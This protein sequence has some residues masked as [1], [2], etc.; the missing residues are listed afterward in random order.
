[1]PKDK[2]QVGHDNLGSRKNRR[3]RGG[4]PESQAEK[5]QKVLSEAGDVFAK[6]EQEKEEAE[7]L[8]QEERGPRLANFK[9]LVFL[10]RMNTKVTVGGFI[11]SMH[12]LNGGEQRE[13]LAKI[14]SLPA[15]NR[16]IYAKPYT[17]WMALDLINDAPV[18]VAAISAGF[19][20]DLE[21]IISWQDGLIER[22]FSEYEL[23]VN[24]AGEVFKPESIDGDLKK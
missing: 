18:D 1:M 10:G 21:F 12:T 11:F 4:I 19:D 24:K 16:L 2:I 8:D 3:S 15:E 6:L 9:D 5:A 22:L 17:L 23:L 13:L 7:V 20:T 14:M